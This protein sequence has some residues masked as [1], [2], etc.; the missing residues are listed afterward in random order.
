MPAVGG[1]GNRITWNHFFFVACGDN[2]DKNRRCGRQKTGVRIQNQGARFR[3]DSELVDFGSTPP[4][5]ERALAFLLLT[6]VS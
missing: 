6:A 2:I 4:G 5:A 3:A 1:A